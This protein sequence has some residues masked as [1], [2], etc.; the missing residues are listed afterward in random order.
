MSPPAT[1][2]A[3]RRWFGTDGVRGHAGQAP[4]LPGWL[5]ALGRAL[6][7]HAGAGGLVLIARDT[8]ESG[9]EIV[10]SVSG[11]LLEGGARVIDLGLMPTAGLPIAMRAR[12]AAAGIVVS[13]SHNPWTDNGLKVFGV[14]GLKLSDERE[15]ALEERIAALLAR[16]PEGRGPAAASL[17]DLDRLDGAAEYSAW[18][19]ARFSRLELRG[20]R[21]LVD[22]ANGA[23][24]A[25]APSVLARLGGRVTALFDRPDGRNINAG[26]GST[27][28]DPLIAG[29]AKGEHDLGMAFDGDADRVLFVDRGG[30]VGN[31]DHLLGFLAPVLARRGE[32]PGGRVIATVMS[33]LGLERAL[34]AAHLSL[35]RTPVGDRHVLAAM[36]QHGAG[37]GGEASGH[38][39]FREAGSAVSGIGPAIG[40]G[41]YTALRL[42]AALEETGADLA[43]VIDAVPHAP[44]VLLNVPVASRPPV[45]SLP[46]LQARVSELGATHGADLRLVL[47]YSGTENLARVMVEGLDRQLV[48][49][50]AAELAQVWA[51]EAEAVRP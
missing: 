21:L 37:L 2:A 11:G 8:R 36:E 34:A 40:D 12:A 1:G 42:L 6:G 27:H 30:R 49:D 24:T 31:G 18:L 44:Q 9:P 48:Q 10:A 35:V 32:L 23:A 3:R 39:L 41:L 33:N 25:C 5:E 14:G 13:A 15:S 45:E 28:L 51:T 38:I 29:M 16:A 43:A 46:R 4:L 50:V 26:C 47:R 20:R 22:C 17:R 19:L 7:E